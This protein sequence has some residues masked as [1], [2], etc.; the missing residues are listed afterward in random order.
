MS[1]RRLP[2]GI[3][4][5][6]KL[7]ARKP[8][9][10]RGRPDAFKHPNRAGRI[11]VTHPN[12]NIKRGTVARSTDRRAGSHGKTETRYVAFLHDDDEPGFGVS[13]PDFPGCVSDG[14]TVDHALR[15]GAEALSLHVE[16]MLADGEPFPS[17]APS[18]T[19]RPTR[20]WPTGE[21]ERP[22]RSSRS[23][24]TRAHRA[25][26]TSLWTSACCAPSTKRRNGAA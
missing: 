14:D 13:L 8:T 4:T 11:T 19:S 18:T 12:R 2:I 20:V 5:F 23:F 25:A 16:A 26:S 15:R 24:S 6:R 9:A 7:R 3:Q 22:S 17:R 1:R 21:T 10:L